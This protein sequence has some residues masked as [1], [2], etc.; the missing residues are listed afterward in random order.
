M[1]DGLIKVE[2]SL[3]QREINQSCPVAIYLELFDTDRLSLVLEAR[4]LASLEVVLRPPRK[5]AL[6]QTR[7]VAV[8]IV[9]APTVA[10]L[11]RTL[12]S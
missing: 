11:G 1:Q 7:G 9:T 2:K 3:G 8:R 10:S 5:N 6:L 12:G 4:P